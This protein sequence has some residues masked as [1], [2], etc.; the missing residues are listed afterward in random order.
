M[1]FAHK[2]SKLT[3]GQAWQSVQRHLG[4]ALLARRP[5]F[6]LDPKR[7][8]DSINSEQFEQI[9]Q[10]YAVPSPGIGWQK[11]LDLSTWIPVNLRRIR[12]LR[13]D[14]GFHKRIL[15]IGCGTGYFLYLCQWLGHDVLGLDINDVPMYGEITRMLGLD[16]VLWRVKA[17]EPLPYLGPRFD[18]ITCFAI[19]FNEHGSKTV[20]RSA[21]WQ[22][23]LDDLALRLRPGGKIHL[24]LNRESTGNFY[25]QELRRLL[26]ARGAEIERNK[27]T[28]CP[29]KRSGARLVTTGNRAGLKCPAKVGQL[30]PLLTKTHSVAAHSR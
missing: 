29:G 14:F 20:W 2:L 5:I 9:R 24:R 10:R 11:Y 17:F 4:L 26:E 25:D 16:R 22:F 21:E 30:Q 3:D 12:D 8:A 6:R 13:L 19:C 28:I 27:I 23:F 18:L 15:D 7:F 1:R